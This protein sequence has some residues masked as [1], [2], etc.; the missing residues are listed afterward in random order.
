MR[1]SG[2]GLTWAVDGLTI[3]DDVDVDFPDGVTTA[4]VGPN[5]SGKTTLLHLIAGL[6]RPSAGRVHL[7]DTD[8]STLSP[9]ARA[10]VMALVEQHPDTALDLTVRQ[11]VELGRIPHEGRWRDRRELGVVDTAME[12]AGV[13]ALEHRRW[14][15]LSGGE[16]QRTQLARALAQAPKALLL[17]EP[18]NHLELRHQIGLMGTIGRLGLTTVVVLHDLDLAAAFAPRLVV[19]DRGR[20]VAQ[21]ATAEV[22]TESLV[23]DVFGVRATVGH[24]DRLRLR[25]HGL[26]EQP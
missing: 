11:V 7:D 16:R 25:W 15:T 13:M 9:R 12:T 1:V 4:I 23:A 10:Q 22:L 24:D 2:S 20:V 19:M 3:V 17:D 8:A 26:T 21:G 5:G 6:R 14:P 18:T